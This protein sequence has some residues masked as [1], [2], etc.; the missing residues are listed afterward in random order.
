MKLSPTRLATAA[1]CLR[2]YF[3]RYVSPQPEKRDLQPLA[4]GLGVHAAM[5]C[6][7]RERTGGKPVPPR[8]QLAEY[9]IEAYREAGGAERDLAAFGGCLGGYLDKL[10]ESGYWGETLPV[11]D[12]V[13]APVEVRLR[14]PEVPEEVRIVGFVDVVLE[15]EEGRRWA[16]DYKVSSR[17]KLA[18]EARLSPQLWVARRGAGVELARFTS[19]VVPGR[20]RAT[21]RTHEP[22]PAGPERVVLGGITNVVRSLRGSE[23]RGHWPQTDPQSFMCKACGYRYLCFPEA[24]EAEVV[25][26]SGLGSM[27][28]AA[29]EMWRR[30]PGAQEVGF[31]GTRRAVIVGAQL[32]SGGLELELQVEGVGS[33]RYCPDTDNVVYLMAA[34]HE[35]DPEDWVGRAVVVR[36]V[37]G[38]IVFQKEA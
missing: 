20:Q 7:N 22:V 32:R 19:F 18:N 25:G 13:E 14:V 29:R 37:K 26:T 30:E 24:P 36:A 1:A 5:E 10:Q 38:R 17:P 35:D 33:V 8:S 6:A 3:Y 28:L 9:A 27:R 4:W 15:D 11:P 31:E 16:E 12:S 2:K 34:L 21:V 23:E